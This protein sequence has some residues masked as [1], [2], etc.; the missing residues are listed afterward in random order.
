LTPDALARI[1]CLRKTRTQNFATTHTKNRHDDTILNH[2][3]VPV[4]VFF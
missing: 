2:L 1:I 4:Q 3:P